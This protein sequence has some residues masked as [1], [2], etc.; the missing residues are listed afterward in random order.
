MS[1]M[2]DGTFRRRIFVQV[3]QP[4]TLLLTACGDGISDL[5]LI[6]TP[7]GMTTPSDLMVHAADKCVGRRLFNTQ[8]GKWEMWVTT[9]AEDSQ[10]TLQ[11]V[12]EK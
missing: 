4:V 10:F 5:V 9:K 1:R 6:P 2:P 12:I 3:G 11:P 8:P 7:A